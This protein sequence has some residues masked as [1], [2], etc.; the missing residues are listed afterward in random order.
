MKSTDG[1]KTWKAALRPPHGDNHDMWIDPTNPKRFIASNDG[2]AT[3]TINGGETWTR[4]I[5]RRRSSTTSSRP[6]TCR[7]TCAA[8]SRTTR[9]ACVSSRA[10]ARRR[11]RAASTPIFYSVGGGESGYI[12]NDPKNPDIF[13]AGSYGGC[14]HAVQ[15]QDGQSRAG[16]PVSGQP[17]GLRDA[18]TSPNASSGRSRSCSRRSIPTCSTS[19]RSTSGRRPTAGTAGRRSA[20]T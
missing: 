20:R 7:I 1:G 17:D 9:T 10:A 4:R 14:D 15:P 8:R 3:V 16:Q 5:I 11:W 2:G 6:A 13:Y 19:A 12:A 18:R